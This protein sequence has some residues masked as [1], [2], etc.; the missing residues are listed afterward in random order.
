MSHYPPHAA[1][2]S[3]GPGRHGGTPPARDRVTAPLLVASVLCTGLMA[4]LFFAY[5][6]SV[7]PGLAEL[8]DAAYAAAMQ[9][10]NAAIDGNA[11]FGLVFLAALALTVAA[12]TVAF[13]RKRRTVA[14]PL[15]VAAVCYLLALV[16]TVAVNLPLNADLAALGDPASAQNLHAVIDDFKSVWVPANIFRTL[17]CVLSLGALC[18]A[19]LRHGKADSPVELRQ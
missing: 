13:R 14:L 19:L 3:A 17:F 9:R 7:M 2:Y 4:G 10:F 12:A 8:D 18:A 5:D 1:P 11:L 6:I 15:T 16:L